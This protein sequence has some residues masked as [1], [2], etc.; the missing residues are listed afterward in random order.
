MA[1]NNASPI[2]LAVFRSQVKMNGCLN[3]ISAMVKSMRNTPYVNALNIKIEMPPKT[4]NGKVK[5]AR[6]I[7]VG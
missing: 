3:A 7:A 2:V 1:F 6:K 4:N 5:G